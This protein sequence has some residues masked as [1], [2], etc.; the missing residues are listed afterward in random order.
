MKSLTPFLVPGTRRPDV[1]AAREVLLP[2][3][4]TASVGEEET[5]RTE[6]RAKSTER[7]ACLLGRNLIIRFRGPEMEWLNLT[8]R[9]GGS[10]ME[11]RNLIIR[12]GTRELQERRGA[13]TFRHGNLRGRLAPHRHVGRVP[14]PKSPPTP[15]L[16]GKG[17]WNWETPSWESRSVMKRGMVAGF[18]NL[19]PPM[20]NHGRH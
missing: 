20:R 17:S 18:S 12:F 1:A 8:V 10:E 2:D 16:L 5:G 13:P 4:E 15:R 14:E 11:R 9:F 19:N 3:M 6:Q 7:R